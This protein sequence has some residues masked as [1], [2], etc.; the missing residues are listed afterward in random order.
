MGIRADTL[1]VSGALTCEI[2]G[3]NGGK[4]GTGGT[5]GTGGNRRTAFATP[6]TVDGSKI[7]MVDSKSGADGA[8]GDGGSAGSIGEDGK[9]EIR[10]QQGSPE[11]PEETVGNAS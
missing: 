7:M 5:G 9:R 1:S 10:E 4:G 2:T 6:I 3:G 11:I 8:G